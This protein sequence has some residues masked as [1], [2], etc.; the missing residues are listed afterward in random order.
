[1]KGKSKLLFPKK[2]DFEYQAENQKV[3]WTKAHICPIFG[4]SSPPFFW[5]GELSTAFFHRL[6]FYE[7]TVD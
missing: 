4:T 1:M 5:L 7:Q 3:V 2:K 6:F